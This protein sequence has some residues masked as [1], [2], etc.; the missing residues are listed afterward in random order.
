MDERVAAN[1]VVW[2]QASAKHVREYDELLAQARDGELFPREVSLLA[3]VLADG[4]L[5][6]HFQSGHGVDDTALVR[7][8]ARQVVGVDYS[9]VAATAAQRRAVD[10]GSPCRYLVAEVPGVPV[11]DGCADL[12]YTGKGA[13]IWMRDL[14]A[15]AR[16]A[17]RVLRPGGSLFVYEAHPAVPL[18]SWDADEPRIRADRSYFA[19]SH[20]NDSF[21]GNGAREWQ[22]NLG[23][24][25]TA[26]TQAGLRL[27]V[28]E[29]YAE[30]FWRPADGTAAAAWSGR[31]P[32][33]YA[34]LAHK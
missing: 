18:W 14:D 2:E 6:V 10:L 24:I 32:N 26:I 16:D 21:P 15:W 13:L 9:S 25:V 7:A 17:A 3:P 22:W 23:Q 30:P 28:L 11:R 34:L 12:V 5:V 33:A 29:E 4:P 31:L 19:D 27:D 1:R 8:G 20:V